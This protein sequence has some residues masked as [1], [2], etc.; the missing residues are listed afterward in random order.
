MQL[1]FLL[2]TVLFTDGEIHIF[3]SN[4]NVKIFKKFQESITDGG[5]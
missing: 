5:T 2:L 4:L 3:I 1:V